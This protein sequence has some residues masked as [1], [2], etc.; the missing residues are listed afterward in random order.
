MRVT[1][2]STGDR[3]MCTSIGDRKM[4]TCFQSPGGDQRPS[5][6]PAIMT[7]P[8]AGDTTTPGACGTSRSGS[9]KK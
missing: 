1:R 9:R 7:R 2:P 8:S 3:L 5:L 4:V 6:G